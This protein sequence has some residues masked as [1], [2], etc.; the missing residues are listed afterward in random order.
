M[1]KG[2][3]KKNGA[4]NVVFL[5]GEVWWAKLGGRGW[6]GCWLDLEVGTQSPVFMGGFCGEKGTLAALTG[7]I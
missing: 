7:R 2:K 3:K 4:G 6:G 5:G 1:G